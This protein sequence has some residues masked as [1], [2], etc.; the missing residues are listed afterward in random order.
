MTYKFSV[1]NVAI[2]DGD[3]VVKNISN[4]KNIE[5]DYS[6][7]T[8]KEVGPDGVLLDEY[9]DE[10]RLTI[11][12]EFT[13]DKFDTN[14]S[15][16]KYY[17]VY[18][19]TGPHNSGIAIT[20]TKCKLTSYRVRTAQ[21]EFLTATITF[22]KT[23]PLTHQPGQEEPA[24]QKIKFGNVYLGD[25]ATLV[26]SFQGNVVSHI[27]PTALGVLLR[28]T[29]EIGGGSLNITVRG[30]VKRDTRLELEQYFINL[31]TSLDTNKNTLTVEYGDMSYSITDCYF[32]EGSLSD[33]VSNHSEF[34]LTFQ[35]SAY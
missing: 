28:S 34:T 24:R 4:A 30:V 10:E 14:L 25:S 33:R 20:F 26:T 19:T 13:D 23:G 8:T 11:T 12:I 2:K 17:D 3:T 21:G 29:Q 5:L 6:I 15:Q 22:S 1:G 16:D 32:T 35:K 27:I 9:K 18:L 7:S 31:L